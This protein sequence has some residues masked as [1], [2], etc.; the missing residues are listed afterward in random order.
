MSF[1]EEA[2]RR[3]AGRD[4]DADS[5]VLR[6]GLDDHGAEHVQPERRASVAILAVARHRR[7]DLRIDPVTCSLIV[8]VGTTAGEN[9]RAKLHDA[10]E[11]RHRV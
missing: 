9:E 11:R 10:R 7:G 3:T 8:V 2:R 5:A 4:A 1:D 6:L